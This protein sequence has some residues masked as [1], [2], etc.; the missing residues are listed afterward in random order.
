MAAELVVAAASADVA[1]VPLEPV[2]FVGGEPAVAAVKELLVAVAAESLAVEVVAEQLYIASPAVPF[3]AAAVDVAVAAVELALAF[4]LVEFFLSS[5]LCY[6]L[7]V[8]GVASEYF[9]HC[10]HQMT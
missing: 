2:E 3:V 1:P 7:T 5:F 6:E 9:H 10:T 8:A 4:E